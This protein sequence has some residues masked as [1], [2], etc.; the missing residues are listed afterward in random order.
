MRKE[1]GEMRRKME[2]MEMQEGRK[3]KEEEKKEKEKRKKRSGNGGKWKKE[4]EGEKNVVVKEVEI[5]EKGIN[6][7][8]GKM[9]IEAR[10]ENIKEIGKGVRRKK[11]S[12]RG[13]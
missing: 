13:W 3:R 12:N 8:W 5:K 10:I 7:I 6:K 2:K 1:L 11:D 4:R 9:E